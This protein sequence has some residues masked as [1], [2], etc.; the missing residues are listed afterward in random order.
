MNFIFE[1][2]IR[3]G[4]TVEEYVQAWERGS[5]IIQQQAGAR[6]TRLFR[7][8]GSPDVLLAIATWSSKN[9]RDEAMIRLAAASE[10]VREIL[11]LH[12]T[13]AEVTVVGEYDESGWKVDGGT[14]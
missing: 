1:I 4:R 2:R 3:K 12:E 10:D 13:I 7:K 5:V 6:G 9:A 11:F 8:I 14:D